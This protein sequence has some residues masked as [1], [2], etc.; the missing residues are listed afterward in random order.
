[1]R[2]TLGIVALIA[3]GWLLHVSHRQWRDVSAALAARGRPSAESTMN[4]FGEIM[5]PILLFAL[6]YVGAKTT[7]VFFWLDA[8]RYLSLFDLAG[9]WFLLVAYGA[10]ITVKTRFPRTL[11]DRAADEQRTHRGAD[12]ASSAERPAKAA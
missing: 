8:E 3:A 5:R 9:F 12:Q 11:L 1:M 4:A 2:Y 6:V 10:Y 7:F